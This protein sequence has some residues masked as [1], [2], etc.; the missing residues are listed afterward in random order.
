[1]RVLLQWAEF[2]EE[3]AWRELNGSPMVCFILS[4][5]VNHYYAAKYCSLLLP[6]NGF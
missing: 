3:C 1:M 6:Q 5:R 4:N 2:I